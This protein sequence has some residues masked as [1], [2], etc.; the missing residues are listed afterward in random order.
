MEM[1]LTPM[2]DTLSRR[3]DSAGKVER[4]VDDDSKLAVSLNVAEFKPEELSVDLDGRVLKI[5]EKHEI[6]QENGYSMRTFVRQWMLPENIDIVD[7]DSKLAV[8]LNVAEFKPEELSVD[9]DGRVL[10]IQGKQE[11]KQENGYSMRYVSYF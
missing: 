6:K 10:K 4:I 9:L 3:E 7:D 11:I 2:L 8:S 5:Q 1:A